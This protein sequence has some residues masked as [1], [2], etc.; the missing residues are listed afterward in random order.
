M[1]LYTVDFDVI[2]PSL[3]THSRCL[4]VPSRFG[5]GPGHHPARIL[6]PCPHTH[7]RHH[8]SLSIITG[9]CFG[10]GLCLR[11]LW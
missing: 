9:L 5:P 3:L 6:P 8:P 7:E 11:K 2:P 10:R 1:S 4:S